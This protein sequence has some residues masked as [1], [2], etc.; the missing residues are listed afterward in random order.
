MTPEEIKQVNKTDRTKGYTPWKPIVLEQIRTELAQC[1]KEKAYVLDYGAGVALPHIKLLRKLFPQHHFD[2]YDC[3]KNVTDS[4]VRSLQRDFYDFVFAS[5][6]L[7]I[8]PHAK[9]VVNVLD[10]MLDALKGDGILVCNFSSNPRKPWH[11]LSYRGGSA[12]LFR[13]LNKRFATVRLLN[14]NMIS[15]LFGCAYKFT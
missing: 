14:D 12:E 11:K 1:K 8:L 9:I 3:G 5:N 2:A 13:M 15:P 10:E 7:N 6:V 4:H